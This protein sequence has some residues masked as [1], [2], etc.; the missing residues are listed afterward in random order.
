VINLLLTDYENCPLYHPSEADEGDFTTTTTTQ[1][2]PVKEVFDESQGLI[3][4]VGRKTFTEEFPKVQATATTT[5][6]WTLRLRRKG[7]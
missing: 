7:T 3:V 4:V 5:V 6:T 2:F 1:R